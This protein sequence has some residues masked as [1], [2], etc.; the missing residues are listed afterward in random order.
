MPKRTQAS[1]NRSASQKIR[2]VKEVQDD[3]ID[4]LVSHD[5]RI[6][7]NER[8]IKVMRSMMRDQSRID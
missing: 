7:Q 6:A 4:V 5:E 1:T 8:D 3:I 2:R